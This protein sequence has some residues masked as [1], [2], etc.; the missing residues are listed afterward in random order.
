MTR[1][2]LYTKID[3]SIY[4]NIYENCRHEVTKKIPTKGEWNFVYGFDHACGFFLQLFPLD[5]MAEF[6]LEDIN[7]FPE[8][9]CI[10]LDSMFDYLT[11]AEL[12]FMLKLFNGN[13]E[14]IDMAYMDLSF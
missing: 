9:E 10:N 11:G 7:G 14:H 4:K 2:N 8:S 5:E 3:E 1:Y 6:E 12:G 13:Q